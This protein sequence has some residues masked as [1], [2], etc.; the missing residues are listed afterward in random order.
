MSES[1]LEKR[2]VAFAKEQGWLSYKFTSPQIAGVP[3]R[4]FVKA[5][6]VL[7]VEFKVLKSGRLTKLQEVAIARLREEQMRVAVV[8]DFQVFKQ[9]LGALEA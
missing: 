3:D 6:Q 1:N 8:D 2:C 5:G 9:T 4:L 7:F